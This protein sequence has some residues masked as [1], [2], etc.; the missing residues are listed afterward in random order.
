MTNINLEMPVGSGV[1]HWNDIIQFEGQPH[2]I[3]IQQNVNTNHYRAVGIDAEG[4]RMRKAWGSNLHSLLEELH[5]F[6]AP[7]KRIIC[8]E[9]EAVFNTTEDTKSPE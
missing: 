4:N 7:R 8:G 9:R 6:S 2:T 3:L 5:L 1:L